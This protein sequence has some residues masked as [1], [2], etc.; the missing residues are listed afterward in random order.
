[1]FAIVW[2]FEVVVGERRPLDCARS[3]Y[4][5]NH[6]CGLANAYRCCDTNCGCTHCGHST[7][8]LSSGYGRPKCG[9]CGLTAQWHKLWYE[10]V[11]VCRNKVQVPARYSI[12]SIEWLKTLGGD[13]TSQVP[14]AT[15]FICK[16]GMHLQP[17]RE[18]SARVTRTTLL[19]HMYTIVVFWESEK[20]LLPCD[21]LDILNDY[22]FRPS[23][24]HPIS[25]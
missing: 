21:I 16:V 17:K 3:V 5:V 19:I 10:H 13:N 1:M 24:K 7:A 15:I 2:Y 12:R 22:R 25:Q 4:I 14:P 20:R 8:A 23:R 11:L 18:S 6:Y 9:H